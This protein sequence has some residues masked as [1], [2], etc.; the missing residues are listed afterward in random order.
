M[1]SCIHVCTCLCVRACLSVCVCNWLT[2]V[3][4]GLE[5]GWAWQIDLAIAGILVHLLSRAGDDA[6]HR[7]APEAPG[8]VLGAL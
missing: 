6:L 5:D 2:G 4:A 8:T 3:G 7:A 1:C